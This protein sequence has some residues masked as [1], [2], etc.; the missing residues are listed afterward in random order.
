MQFKHRPPAHF[1]AQNEL[2]GGGKP[3]VL[4]TSVSRGAPRVAWQRILFVQLLK[5]QRN[6]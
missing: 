1:S 5:Q 6:E 4:G 2:G 3:A